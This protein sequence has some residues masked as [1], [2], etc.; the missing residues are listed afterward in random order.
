MSLHVFIIF[1]L[2]VCAAG[3]CHVHG[4]EPGFPTQLG[5]FY[6]ELSEIA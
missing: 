3:P 2:N 5:L 6:K 4:A 1:S